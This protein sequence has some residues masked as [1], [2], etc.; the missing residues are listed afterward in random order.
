M[1]GVLFGAFGIEDGGTKRERE[2]G[3]EGLR[4]VLEDI[5]VRLTSFLCW[6]GGRRD[7]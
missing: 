2:E 6:R 3:E 7:I 1:S 4:V 5:K